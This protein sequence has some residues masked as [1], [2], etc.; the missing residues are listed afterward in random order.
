M[1]NVQEYLL[2]PGEVEPRGEYVSGHNRKT[3]P[4]DVQTKGRLDQKC[5][6]VLQHEGKL[7]K[8]MKWFDSEMKKP[9]FRA[10]H[11][12]KRAALVDELRAANQTNAS[13]AEPLTTPKATLG[14][15][16]H[17][18]EDITRDVAK[19]KAKGR[20]EVYTDLN[21]AEENNGRTWEQDN[22]KLVP[23]RM[24][25]GTIKNLIF[26]WEGPSDRW[27][28]SLADV[29]EIE[30]RAG[31]LNTG[32]ANVDASDVSEAAAS[33]RPSLLPDA[34]QSGME[35]AEIV[36]ARPEQVLCVPPQSAEERRLLAAGA[37]A[38][39]PALSPQTAGAPNSAPAVG[40]AGSAPPSV[41]NVPAVP[42]QVVPPTPQ[43]LYKMSLP[44]KKKRATS[45]STFDLE[46]CLEEENKA[47]CDFLLSFREN[48]FHKEVDAVL[49]EIRANH[50]SL[51]KP[52]NAQ[53]KMDEVIKL[54][55]NMDN[56]TRCKATSNHN[57]F[58]ASATRI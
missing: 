33:A 26:V 30:R 57:G 50:D 4:A 18:A 44:G 41:P 11:L 43:Q 46:T 51:L 9:S 23:K 35:D 19:M 22:R 34:F 38:H 52:V 14:E 58:A 42:P 32:M 28:M 5:R 8:G 10:S 37:Q 45:M 48:F 17:R 6:L 27:T 55:D 1:P 3:A 16:D 20:Y 25:D 29:A 21:Y 31:I 24:A 36:D 15:P 12:K 53:R 13:G 49:L 39:P 40:H 54:R 2:N 47:Y 56:L 7:G